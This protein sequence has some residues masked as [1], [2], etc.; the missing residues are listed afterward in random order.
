MAAREESGQH[1]R[2]IV[3]AIEPAARFWRAE[4]YHQRYLEKATGGSYQS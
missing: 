2:P 3:T 1:E 4:E